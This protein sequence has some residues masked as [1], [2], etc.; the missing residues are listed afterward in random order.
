M[1]REHDPKPGF[2]LV[3]QTF[4]PL[5]K[6]RGTERKEKERQGMSILSSPRPGGEKCFPLLG[7]PPWERGRGGKGAERSRGE[8]KRCVSEF[9]P[10]LLFLLQTASRG[11]QLSTWSLIH[12]E[13]RKSIFELTVHLSHPLAPDQ[14]QNHAFLTVFITAAVL[15][16]GVLMAVED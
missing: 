7:A 13:K 8:E 10:M 4:T 6:A 5:D 1:R 2:T 11:G 15:H 16:V 9:L 3:N 12:T 14:E